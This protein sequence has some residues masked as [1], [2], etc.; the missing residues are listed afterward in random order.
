MNSKQRRL[1]IA[2]TPLWVVIAGVIFIIGLIN[3]PKLFGYEFVG[4]DNGFFLTKGDANE[5]RIAY[6]QA[7]AEEK[8]IM[9]PYHRAWNEYGCAYDMFPAY[10]APQYV[11]V[12]TPTGPLCDPA[13]IR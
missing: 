2:L 12:M 11:P 9:K 3:A 13:K 6:E 5:V 4:I 1:M 10:A 7:M 8:S